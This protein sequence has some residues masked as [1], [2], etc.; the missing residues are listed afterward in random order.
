MISYHFVWMAR[1]K[2]KSALKCNWTEFVKENE[3]ALW[4]IV[5]NV[6]TWLRPAIEY[7][8][9]RGVKLVN[10]ISNITLGLIW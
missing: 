9:V 3:N 4:V 8:Q 1:L 6:K 10:R 5:E 2:K 7:Y